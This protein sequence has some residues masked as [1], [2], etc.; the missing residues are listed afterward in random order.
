MFWVAAFGV[1]ATLAS[2]VLF[3]LMFVRI[4][5][6]QSRARGAAQRAEGCVVDMAVIALGDLPAKARTTREA[7]QQA[8]AWFHA[9]SAAGGELRLRYVRAAQDLG[10]S[11]KLARCRS[12][13]DPDYRFIAWAVA[14]VCESE[15]FLARNLPQ[16]DW[17]IGREA[18]MRLAQSGQA[19]FEEVALAWAVKR[20][21]PTVDT[22]GLLA[23]CR[24]DHVELLRGS[25]AA[26]P[27]R[28]GA[29][30]LEAWG[31]ACPDAARRLARDI[32]ADAS[33]EGWLVCAAL[34]QLSAP[35]DVSWA[36]ARLHDA[37][38][39]V[40]LAAV[41]TVSRLGTRADVQRL[42]VFVNDPN[43]WL[44]RRA[45]EALTRAQVLA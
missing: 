18:A 19:S 43:Y 38:W 44:R 10:L 16:L 22:T 28:R 45:R 13:L 29:R 34:R 17:P 21:I 8:F 33:S 35:A 30:L 23:R 41:R 25:L 5:H 15:V 20:R 39:A 36:I 2:A 37:H 42:S 27:A 12:A 14:A 6:A 24:F 9:Y 32:L 4:V 7:L 40:R 31:A 1:A 11:A 26:L 3:A